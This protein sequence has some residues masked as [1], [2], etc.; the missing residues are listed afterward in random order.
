MRWPAASHTARVAWRS[1]EPHSAARWS[2]RA[3][4]GSSSARRCGRCSVSARYTSAAAR[5]R[6]GI[7]SMEAGKPRWYPDRRGARGAGTPRGRPARAAEMAT[8]PGRC[9]R[10]AAGPDPTR[11]ATAARVCSR[12]RWARR[13]GRCRG[14]GRPFG[15]RRHRHRRVRAGRPPRRRGRRRLS[16]ARGYRRTSNP[17]VPRTTGRCRGVPTPERQRAGTAPRRGPCPTPTTR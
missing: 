6:A 1:S 13:G 5:I 12:C 9:S 14:G 8:A 16:N 11:K 3:A 4:A 7:E 15:S 17:R 2:S 10:C